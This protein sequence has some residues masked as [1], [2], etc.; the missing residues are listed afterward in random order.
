VTVAPRHTVELRL[1]L[2]ASPEAIF[3]FLTEPDRYVT[4]QGVRA[5]LDPRPG[6]VYRVWMDADTVASGEF[7]EVIA[8][9]RVVFTWGWE[10]DDDVPPGST[11][12]EIDLA[13][14]GPGTA[15]TL[16]HSG[17][18][19]GRS[20]AMHRGGWE[21]FTDRLSTASAGGDPGPMSPPPQAVSVERTDP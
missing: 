19:D 15:L 17:L 14:D 12:V 6:G 16:R 5:E 9:E 3:P 2:N 7:V 11:R 8:P 18:P 20:A 10:G 4:W 21:I 1:Q 13:A